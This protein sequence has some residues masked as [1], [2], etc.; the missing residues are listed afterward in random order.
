MRSCGRLQQF[1]NSPFNPKLF[2]SQA[3]TEIRKGSQASSNG[4]SVT[5]EWSLTEPS[6][7]TET[8]HISDTAWAW[9]GL[10]GSVSCDCVSSPPCGKFLSAKRVHEFQLS[11]MCHDEGGIG[12]GCCEDAYGVESVGLGDLNEVRS[13]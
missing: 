6:R 3:P 1:K 4:F 13:A 8:C 7:V 10:F 12:D 2:I 5:T 11:N 9:L